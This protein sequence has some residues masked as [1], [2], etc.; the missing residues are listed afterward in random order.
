MLY[1][2]RLVGAGFALLLLESHFL[3]SSAYADPPLSIGVSAPLSGDA[4]TYG[5]DIKNVLEFANQLLAGGRYRLRFEDDKCEGAAAVTAAQKL[6]SQDQV[7]YILGPICTTS[8]GA[9]APV[10]SKANVLVITPTANLDDIAS[11][12]ATTFTTIPSDTKA[13]EPLSRFVCSKHHMVGILSEPTDMAQQMAAEFGRKCEADKVTVVRSDFQASDRDF[14]SH[15]LRLKN[16]GVEALFINTQTEASFL[17]MLRQVRELRLNVEIYGAMFPGTREFL[18][19]AGNLAEGIIFVDLPDIE[20][21]LNQ[22]GKEVYARFT[23]AYGKMQSIEF[24]F[25]TAFESFRVLQLAIE[26]GQPPAAYLRAT[27]FDG[28]LGSYTFGR[29]GVIS[30]IDHVMKIVRNGKVQP[31]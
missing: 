6:V 30:G 2:R 27:K 22:G 15:L 19:K 20:H 24:L 12:G 28:L 25:A 31:L 1:K 5:T 29:D 18:E 8:L 3:S 23:S 7:R 10:Y 16:A 13:M 26:S 11:A 21:A 9:S 4:A 17:S 14:R